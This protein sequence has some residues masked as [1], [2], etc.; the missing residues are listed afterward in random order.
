MLS[1]VARGK[2]RATIKERHV[3]W[4]PVIINQT[5]MGFHRDVTTNRYSRDI[6]RSSILSNGEILFQFGD[7]FSKNNAGHFLGLTDNTCAIAA[8]PKN[9]T[10]SSYRHRDPLGEDIIKPFIKLEDS[11]IRRGEKIWSFSGIVERTDDWELEKTEGFNTRRIVGWTFFEVCQ[12]NLTGALPTYCY[13]G[14]AKVV[15]DMELKRFKT[16]RDGESTGRHVLFGTN[17][18]RFN[19]CAVACDEHI[20]L[21]GQRGSGV[22]NS[23]DIYVARVHVNFAD[24]RHFYEFWNGRGWVNNVRNCATILRDMQHG[25]VFHTKM[26]GEGQPYTWAFI[27]CNAQGDSKVQMGRSMSPEGP[28]EIRETTASLYCLTDPPPN[29]YSYCVYP[30]PDLTI[31]WSE[32][33][34]NGAVL[35]SKIR[36]QMQDVPI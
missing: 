23:K 17:E 12:K 13:T 19:M 8:D 1:S 5:P 30:H 28:W 20:Y 33:G 35:M 11:E 6:G 7:T 27:G 4:P 32:G 26:F 22:Y 2:M 16:Y 15:Y 3:A 25:Q 24:Q 31:S 14:I 21:Y 10:L 34:M 29:P 9:P 36:F 18:P